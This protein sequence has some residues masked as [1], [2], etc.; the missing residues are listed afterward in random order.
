[1]PLCPSCGLDNQG[2]SNYCSKCGFEIY[3]ATGRISPDTLLEDRYLIVVTIGDMI[4]QAKT[5]I[6][7]T[8]HLLSELK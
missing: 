4:K 7:L 8:T 2:E 6:M 3:S 5:C 1:M